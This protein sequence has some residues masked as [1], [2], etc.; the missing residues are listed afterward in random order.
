MR[1]TP[2]TMPY[3]RGDVVLLELP[4]SDGTAT[5]KRP[6]LIVAN[7]TYLA[8]T[9]DLIVCA[10]TSQTRAERIVGATAVRRWREA[11]LLKRSVV[12]ASIH[13][14]DRASVYRRLGR[15]T[16]EDLARV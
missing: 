9:S 1:R 2:R 3:E 4:F 15:L 11:R 14:L 8:S 6:A 12:K 5:K 13:T 10:I 7:A 16:T